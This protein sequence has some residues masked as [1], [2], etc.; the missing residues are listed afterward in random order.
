[1]PK[2]RNVIKPCPFCGGRG[3]LKEKRTRSHFDDE[4]IVVC[5]RCHVHSIMSVDILDAIY[6]WNNEYCLSLD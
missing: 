5:K 3:V 6:A 4:F 2:L 1:M